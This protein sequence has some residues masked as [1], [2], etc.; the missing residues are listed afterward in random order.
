MS[1]VSSPGRAWASYLQAGGDIE[2]MVPSVFDRQAESVLWLT[3]G[4]RDVDMPAGVNNDPVAVDRAP[5]GRAQL[6]CR[7][8]RPWS[9]W[10]GP[11]WMS[12][13]AG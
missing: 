4:S 1:A 5:S 2:L 13:A 11:A 10:S 8:R 7:R 6:P 9:L 3:T 12:L